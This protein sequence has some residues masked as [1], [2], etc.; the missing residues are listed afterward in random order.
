MLVTSKKQYMPSEMSSG[1]FTSNISISLLN[2]ANNRPIGV[3]SKN[4]NGALVIAHNMTMCKKVDAL[5]VPS[6]GARSHPIDANA[7]EKF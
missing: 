1:S 4:V 2:L 7:D 3:T 5:S 6:L